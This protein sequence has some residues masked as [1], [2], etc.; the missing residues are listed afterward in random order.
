MVG[1]RITREQLGKR[2]IVTYD[3]PEGSKVIS[4]QIT[5]VEAGRFVLTRDE[6]VVMISHSLV[7]VWSIIEGEDQ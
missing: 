1:Q 6:G 5:N 3:T 2:V 4:G 7:I